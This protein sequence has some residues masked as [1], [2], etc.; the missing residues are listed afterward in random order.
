MNNGPGD[1]YQ[2]VYDAAGNR[3]AKG[4]LSAWPAKPGSG[5][6]VCP[7]PTGSTFT[8]TNLYLLGQGGEQ[9]TELTVNAGTVAWAHS[10][11]WEGGRLTGTYDS[12][13]LHFDIADP[14]GTKRVQVNSSG[15]PE[16][17]CL[18][19]PWGNDFN[20]TFVPDCVTPS[21]GSAASDATE[22]HFTKKERDNESGNDYFGARYYASSVGRFMSP[23]WSA[24]V[25]PVPYAK[26]DNP[27]SLN[28][29]VYVGNNPLVGVDADGH[30]YFSDIRD[31]DQQQ[32]EEEAQKEDPQPP[33]KDPPP[34]PAQQPTGNPGQPTG[35]DGKPAPPP[36][37][38]P[39]APDMPWVWQPDPGN[40]RGGTWGP[41]K[42]NWNP[43]NGNAPSASWENPSPNGGQGHWDVDNGKGRKNGG[44]TQV[45]ADGRPLT[46]EEAH[47]PRWTKRVGS[48][49]SDHKGAI[50][51][52]VGA[53][54]V[55]G[56]VAAAAVTGG[57]SL[58]ALVLVP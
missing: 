32:A 19:F 37:P 44:R 31:K 55:V 22:H 8:L 51:V 49:V 21:G 41:G 36:V 15:V 29:Y 47:G 3:V 34:A 40:E 9:V 10:N 11:A 18:M 5:P 24:K 6:Y 43:D 48:W 25:E 42:G 35:A 39:G 57:A 23:D 4:Q 53:A 14:L 56:A 1:M 38:M 27:Q 26:L 33:A 45:G 12:A 17:N 30:D 7:A 13:G 2:Y 28:L 58:G 52:G 46:P 20:N 16:L 50:A 54:I